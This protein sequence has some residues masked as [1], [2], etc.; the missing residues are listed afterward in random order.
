MA[1]REM[2]ETPYGDFLTLQEAENITRI[3]KRNVRSKCKNN[4]HS[5][6]GFKIKKLRKREHLNEQ[7]N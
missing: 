3:D 7:I 1:K 2:Y 6:W 4:N 5:G